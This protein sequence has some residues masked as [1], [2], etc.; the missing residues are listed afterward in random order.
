MPAEGVILSGIRIKRIGPEN[1]ENSGETRLGA[2]GARR[3]PNLSGK[4]TE[5]VFHARILTV[6]SA[7]YFAEILLFQILFAELPEVRT[8]PIFIFWRKAL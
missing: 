4:R 8:A 6:L 5:Q 2:E 1:T 7:R 3:K